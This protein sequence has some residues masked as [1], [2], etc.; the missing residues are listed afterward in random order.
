MTVSRVAV[1]CGVTLSLLT[2]SVTSAWA[3]DCANHNAKLDGLRADMKQYLDQL[4]R[5]GKIKPLPHTDAA[6]CSSAAKF[7]HSLEDDIADSLACSD[8]AAHLIESQYKDTTV[9]L[10]HFHC[11]NPYKPK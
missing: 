3:S 2:V 8:K 4:D 10:A 6:L 11:P 9:I 7:W 5:V 1:F